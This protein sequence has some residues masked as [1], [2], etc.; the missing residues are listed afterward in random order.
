MVLDESPVDDGE[1]E[2]E[3]GDG[4]RSVTTDFTGYFATPSYGTDGAG[5]VSYDLILSS[6]EG[7][8]SGLYALGSGGEQGDPIY[9]FANDGVIEGKLNEDDTEAYFTISVDNDPESDTFGEVTFTQNMNIWH[10]DVNDADDV[11]PLSTEYASDLTLVQTVTDADGDKTTATIDLGQDVFSIE[12]D[13]PSMI[14]P[15]SIHILDD[16]TSPNITRDLNF[17][18]GTDGVG[19][20]IFNITNG[21]PATDASGNLLSFNGLQLYLYYGVDQTVLIASTVAPN[22]GGTVNISNTTTT[23]FWLDINPGSDT[24][25]MHSNGIIEN[26]TGLTS[27]PGDVV[28]PGNVEFVVMTDL[29]TTTK[30]A[31]ITGSGSINT[32]ANSIGISDGQDFRYYEATNNKPLSY[33]GIRVDFVNGATYLDQ[34]TNNKNDDDFSYTNHFT[35]NGYSQRVF[36]SGDTTGEVTNTAN[37]TI[38]AIVANSGNILYAAPVGEVGETYVNLSAGN[39]RVYNGASLMQL[40]TDYN[41]IDT[42]PTDGSVTITGL[43][44]GW[45][46]QVLTG[47]VNF[48]AIQIDAATGTDAFKLDYFTIGVDYSGDPVDL[49]YNIVGTDGDGDAISGLINATL[50]PDSGRTIEGTTGDDTGDNALVSDDTSQYILGNEGNDTLIGNGGD[51]VLVGDTGVDRLFGGTGNDTLIADKFD[52]TIDGGTGVDTLMFSQSTSIDF[53]SLTDINPTITNIEVIDLSVN[54]N[55][56]LLNITIQD[57]LDMTGGTNTL[58]ILGD[59]AGDVVKLSNADGTWTHSGTSIEAIADGSMHTFDLYTGIVNPGDPTVTLKVE[60]PISDTIG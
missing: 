5:S 21:T 38:T 11:A 26:G 50:Y 55:H 9:L 57:V 6:D 25:T 4:I 41:V 1:T 59:S 43:Q 46:F 37:I 8:E 17:V 58:T 54:G 7:V 47:D 20:V 32:N 15:V 60:Q 56:Q 2:V 51:D 3:E 10:E 19:N 29:G 23:G 33:D 13:A 27:T 39:I 42:N 24:Y 52:H 48:S 14:S 12:D 28:N 34:G 49:Q 44:D 16:V 53:S 36:V 40:G 31:I 45:T 18:A 22:S 30:D 35:T